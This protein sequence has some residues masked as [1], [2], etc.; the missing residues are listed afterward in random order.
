MRCAQKPKSELPCYSYASYQKKISVHLAN[1]AP[2]TQE[3]SAF[4]C[5]L[6]VTTTEPIR[7]NK[8]EQSSRPP[9]ID[10]LSNLRNEFALNWPVRQIDVNQR[11]RWLRLARLDFP[12]TERT[13]DPLL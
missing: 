8:L 6:K 5:G 2:L 11:P 12:K 7:R 13:A 4:L 3:I 10:A 1:I 9:Y